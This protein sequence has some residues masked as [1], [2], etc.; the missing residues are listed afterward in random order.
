[1][2]DSSVLGWVILGVLRSP[3]K[4]RKNKKKKKRKSDGG[5]GG[6][7]EDEVEDTVEDDKASFSPHQ[8]AKTEQQLKKAFYDEK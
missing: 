3:K 5:D 8:P 7:T 2:S 6:K 1:M 4:K